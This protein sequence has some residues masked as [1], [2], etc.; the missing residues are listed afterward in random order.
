MV[1]DADA[2]RA[3]RAAHRPCPVHFIGVWED[4]VKSYGGLNP[5]IL[6]HLR[7]NPSVTHVRHALALDE[8]RAWFKPT[9][10]GQL[11]IDRDKAMTRVDPSDEPAYQAQDI[12]EVWFTGCHGDIGGGT[13]ALRWM[14][15]EAANVKP[16]LL[17]GDSGVS[18]LR[19]ADSPDRPE[20]HQSWTRT[21]RA[22]EQI[23]R[24][25]IDNSGVYPVKVSHRGSDGLRDPG[26]SRRHG[27]VGVHA[28]VVDLHS[29]TDVAIYETKGYPHAVISEPRS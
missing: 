12:S 5:V 11:D 27:K 17:V 24:R 10:W 21:W 19:T 22:V 14:L 4:T 28:S 15:G 18:L 8:R 7:H 6:P 13:L 25:G 16:P 9:T 2:V 20:I 29:V 26:V 1:A 23:P 3:L